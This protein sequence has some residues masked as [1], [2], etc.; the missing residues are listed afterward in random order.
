[1]TDEK[2]QIMFVS[3][4]HTTDE[5]LQNY[6]TNNNTLDSL[7]QIGKI[8]GFVSSENIMRTFQ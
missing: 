8:E 6:T 7:Q 5:A 1:M 2:Q 3:T 4:G